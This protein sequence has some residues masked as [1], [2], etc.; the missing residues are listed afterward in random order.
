MAAELS[1]AEQAL[2][3]AAREYHRLPRPGKISI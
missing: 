3:E 2:R 1:Q